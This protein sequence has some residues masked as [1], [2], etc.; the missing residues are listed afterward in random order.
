M[1]GEGIRKA[2]G[3]VLLLVAILAAAA[4]IVCS[5]PVTAEAAR[6]LELGIT[7]ALSFQ[8]KDASTRA[9]WLDRAVQARANPVIVTVYWPNVAPQGKAPDDPANPFDPD[10]DWDSTD[11]AVRDAT[12]RGLRVLFHITGAPRWAEGPD[13][14]PV[15]Q[16]PAGTWLPDP[17]A[18]GAFA[19]AIATRFSGR[20]PGLP[21]VGIYQAWAEPNLGVNLMP[22]FVDATPVGAIHYRAMLNAFYAGVKSVNPANL[23]VTAG[24]APYGDLGRRQ[25]GF[26]APRTQPLQFWRPFFCLTEGK[27]KKKKGKRK[28]GKRARAAVLR[29]TSCPN[30]PHFDALSHHP[31]NVGQPGRHAINADDVST[32][33]LGKIK[34]ILQKA[35]HSGRAL[36]AGPKQLWAT[37][38]YWNSNPPNDKGPPL[39]LHARWLEEAFYLLWKQGVSLAIWFEIRD[40]P[41]QGS[42]GYPIPQSGLFFRDGTA[43]PAFSAF[44]FP[45][46]A[47]RKKA[48]GGKGRRVQVWGKAPAPGPVL[49]QRGGGSKWKKIKRLKAGSNRIFVGT[50]RLRRAAT[51][52]AQQGSETSLPWRQK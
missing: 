34:R 49:I 37:E 2:R 30:P 20:F 40:Y 44:R 3:G 27:K 18:F 50:I 26:F 51:L 14:P 52:R 11:A 25:G 7:D 31:I 24:T 28:K 42:G 15:A 36:P 9:L 5:S 38:I 41:P 8:D 19:T 35:E 10:Y 22:Q 47:G 6:P 21:R 39:A 13:R 43:K 33:D 16:A 48:K 32:P 17:G 12:A 4:A 1:R 45:F 29:G 46:A 23:V